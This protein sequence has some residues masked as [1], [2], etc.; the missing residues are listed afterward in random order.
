MIIIL[1]LQKD[2]VGC[3]VITSHTKGGYNN[4]IISIG[5]L[6]KKSILGFNR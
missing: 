1:K 5:V 2:P 3:W 6:S 4:K